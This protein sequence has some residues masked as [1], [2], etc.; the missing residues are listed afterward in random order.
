[1]TTRQMTAGETVGRGVVV[2]A[3]TL[4]AATLLAGVVG[5]M[6]RVSMWSAMGSHHSA[7]WG[8]IHATAPGFQMGFGLPLWTVILL[9]LPLAVL[10][11]V[12]YVLYRLV[13]DRGG[14]DDETDD[15]A[16][17]ELRRAYAR[18]DLSDEEFDRR[19]RR[20]ATETRGSNEF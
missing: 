2:A 10:A 16:I 1:M 8:P 3:G 15:A 12:G 5:A 17:A 19:E 13:V 20:L 7:M 18:G 4:L 9:A 6:W 14:P 11:G